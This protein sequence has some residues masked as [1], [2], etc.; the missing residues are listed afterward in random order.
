MAFGSLARW[1]GKIPGNYSQ[2]IRFYGK[3]SGL[4]TGI[5]N[6][7]SKD[8]DIYLPAVRRVLQHDGRDH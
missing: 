6:R 3:A 1:P 5:C 7:D 2:I 8:H 4:S